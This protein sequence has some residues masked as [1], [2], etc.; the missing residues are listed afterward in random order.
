[1]DFKKNLRSHIF[2]NGSW[3]GSDNVLPHTGYGSY[4]NFT[5][6]ELPYCFSEDMIE[7]D[8]KIIRYNRNEISF[9][10]IDR[11]TEIFDLVSTET[12][13]EFSKETKTVTKFDLPKDFKLD[14]TIMKLFLFKVFK[15]LNYA[16][17]KVI[18]SS[19]F[20]VSSDLTPV[21]N[22]LKY[23]NVEDALN[24]EKIISG[25]DK[26]TFLSLIS[27]AHFELSNGRKLKQIL[28]VPQQI[29]N[30]LN[31]NQ[32]SSTVT[33]FKIICA[34]DPNEGIY[35][36]DYFKKLANIKNFKTFKGDE[37]GNA[38]SF[39]QKIADIKL[40]SSIKLNVLIPY[41][42]KQKLHYGMH[43]FQHRYYARTNVRELFLPPI[44]E[45]RTYYD[46]VNLGGTE[47]TPYILKIAH[48]SLVKN[49]RYLKMPKVSEK[50]AARSS[51]FEKYEFSDKEFTITYPKSVEDLVDEGKAL[52]H[53]VASYSIPVAEG[54]TRVF[55]VRKN[56]DLETPFVTVELDNEDQIVQ[57][58]EKYDIDVT[59]VDV[60]NFLKKWKKKK[61]DA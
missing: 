50:I 48:D 11:E 56:N 51:E 21:N 59:D 57:T 42:I 45:A 18:Y 43:Q 13:I 54:L 34:D 41:L 6:N 10:L 14:S 8:E 4:N 29:I 27:D 30:F 12:Y 47:Q 16:V 22:L 53:C 3:Y 5:I 46:Y 15:T 23:A 44:E 17:S 35:L 9:N 31:E 28:E 49:S 61:I 40:K 1:M 60:L 24:L 26:R 32:L 58:K 38:S 36:I 55:F 20:Y 7:E 25:T 2:Y 19:E 52:C 39:I 33:S 37:Y